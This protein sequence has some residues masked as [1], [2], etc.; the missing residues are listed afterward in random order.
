MRSRVSKLARP[1]PRRLLRH[2]QRQKG[3]GHHVERRHAGYH[4]Q[5]LRDVAQRLAPQLQDLAR[6]GLGDVKPADPDLSRLREIVAVEDAHDGGLARPALAGQRDAFT[7]R[8]GES[9]AFD[10]RDRH[11]ALVVQREGF[12]EIAYVYHGLI[13]AGRN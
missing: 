13:P 3:L 4:A 9:R 5:E 10:D 8:D 7:G 2:A 6:R 11:A 1:V 12:S